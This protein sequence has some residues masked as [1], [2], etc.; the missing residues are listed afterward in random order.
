AESQEPAVR[1]SG[2]RR[3]RADAAHLP[4][5]PAAQPPRAD[6]R[7]RDAHRAAGD[8]AGVV[9]VVPRDRRHAPHAQLGQ[10]RRGRAERAQHRPLALVAARLPLRHAGRH[11]PRAQLRGRGPARSPGPQAR[12]M[13][14]DAPTIQTAARPARHADAPL[15]ELRD[16]TVSFDN[17]GGPRILAVD[18]ASMSV[19]E[20]Q[21]LAVVGESGCGKSITAL[22]VLGLAP[23]PP[24]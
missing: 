7:L 9:P 20:G 13:T 24:A 4:A 16:L 23:S 18:G 5:P 3:G 2:A 22:S 15:I 21:T 17:P 12:A 10:S 1:G 6:H 19:Y 8:P 14:S 11:A